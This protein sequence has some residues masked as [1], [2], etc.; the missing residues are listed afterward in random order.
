MRNIYNE[1]IEEIT[2][3]FFEFNFDVEYPENYKMIGGEA[4]YSDFFELA[5]VY[6]NAG[7]KL[8]DEAK[9]NLNDYFMINPALFCYRQSIELFLKSFLR[10]KYDDEFIRYKL[11]H[12][13][14]KILDQFTIYCREKFEQ[15][16]PYWFNEIILSFHVFDEKSDAFRYGVPINKNEHLIHIGHLKGKMDALFESFNTIKKMRSNL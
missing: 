10:E 15:V 2:P 11:G 5:I 13:L 7:D 16:P 6:K 14:Q 9:D 12:N 8:M 4:D 3:P 1:L